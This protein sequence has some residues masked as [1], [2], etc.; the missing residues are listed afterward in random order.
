MGLYQSSPS[1]RR[2]IADSWLHLLDKAN[3]SVHI[4]AFYFTLRGSDLEFAGSSD[5]QV[6]S[7]ACPGLMMQY[8][9]RLYQNIIRTS[10]VLDIMSA[11]FA[12]KSGL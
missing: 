4:A 2:S 6:S 8:I 9:K 7:G 10:N 5:S 12:G 3:S 1:S 11:Y